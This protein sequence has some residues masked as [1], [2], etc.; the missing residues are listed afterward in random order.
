VIDE[1]DAPTETHG[2]GDTAVGPPPPVGPPPGDP[3][4][5]RIADDIG[6]GMILILVAVVIAAAVVAAIL[7]TRG[8]HHTNATT[9]TVVTTAPGAP[10][11][12][13]PTAVASVVGRP[14]TDATAAL[15]RSGLRVAV[16]NVAGRPPAG[17]VVA[18]SPAAGG[19]I[20]RGG[21]VTVNVSDGSRT[22]AAT[23]TPRSTGTT[24]QRTTTTRTTTP[25]RTPPPPKP[26]D[27]PS[28]SGQV[29]GAVQRLS[30]TGLLV[31][32]QY[33]PG[34]Q[35]LGT[36]TA[37]SPDGGSSATTGSHVTRS[38]SSGPGGNPTETVPETTGQRIPQ[39]VQ[40]PNHAGLRL[41]LLRRTVTD[42]SQAGYVVDETPGAG[43]RAPKNAQVLVYMGAYRGTR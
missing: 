29:K 7:L 36:V 28:L 41:V 42:Q 37:Q 15:R 12:T 40:T 33:V 16:R 31:S 5:R 35:P 1:A 30:S 43:Q 39:A 9:T 17:R 27:V 32:V 19:T 38:V 22:G 11:S 25:A 6:R 34:D 20:R 10:G 21:L 23:T 8:H 13:A 24:P 14:A 18:Q 26:V 3:R 4:G 2:L